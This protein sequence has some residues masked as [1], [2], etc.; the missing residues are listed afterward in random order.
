MLHIVNWEVSQGCTYPVLRDINLFQWNNMFHY[1]YPKPPK[2]FV[3]KVPGEKT[4]Q[5]KIRGSEMK[6]LNFEETHTY[7]SQMRFLKEV[8][9][10]SNPNGFPSKFNQKFQRESD[11]LSTESVI[12]FSS[13]LKC[14]RNLRG[15]LLKNA[16][17]VSLWA[18]CVWMK[19]G[20]TF[21]FLFPLFSFF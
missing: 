12:R 7:W 3:L 15:K 16:K 9:I 21:F 13:G 14:K 1:C 8:S 4:N 5:L 18:V 17:W 20:N 10:G 11:A 2:E 6:A 19:M